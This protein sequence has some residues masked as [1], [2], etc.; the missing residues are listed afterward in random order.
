MKL[1]VAKTPHASTRIIFVAKKGTP[2]I[3]DF[4]SGKGDVAVRY[5]GKLTEIY[6]GLGDMDNCTAGIV[7]TAAANG[8]KMAAQLKRTEVSLVEPDFDEYDSLWASACVEGALLGAYAF[9]KYKSEKPALV[10]S[11]EYAGSRLTQKTATDILT[12]CEC[13]HWARDLVNDNASVVHPQQLA[14]EAKKV[15]SSKSITLEVLDEKQIAAKGLGLLL[16]VGEGSANPPRLII[17][18]YKG[19]PAAKDKTALVGKGVTFDSG[20]QNLKPTGSIE[21]MRC[22]MAGAAVVLATIKALA[23]LSAKINVVGVIPAVHNAVDGKSFFPGDTYTSYSGKT[24]EI[25]S[26]DA[27]GRLILADAISYALKIYK[28]TKIIDLATLTG[29][30]LIALGESIAGLFSNDDTLAHNLFAAGEKTGERLWRLPLYEEHGDAIK[31]EIADLRNTSKLKKGHAGSIMGAA[32][33]KEFVGDVPWAHLDIA[34]TAFNEGDARGEVPKL[35][36]GFGVRLLLEYLT[37]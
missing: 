22:D 11:V 32:F 10:T 17:I 24:V 21:T 3:K 20:G 35:G 27:E 28:P 33:I 18:E 26:T 6:C 4:E 5:E 29:A 7:R 19:N 34:G 36:T 1:N 30:I 14:D 37:H 25:T 2:K 9:T 16:A 31:G 12:V 15:S 8:I 13:V 23:S